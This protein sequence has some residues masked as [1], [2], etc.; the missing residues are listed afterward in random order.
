[1][2][3]SIR[4][5]QLGANDD[6][7]LLLCWNVKNNT[8]VKKGDIICELETTKALYDI[9]AETNGYVY[10]L[11]EEGKSFKVGEILAIISENQMTEEQIQKWIN[12]VDNIP[13]YDGKI[14][15]KQSKATEKA[16]LL[17]QLNGVD[18]GEIKKNS[19]RITESDVREYIV[20][21]IGFTKVIAD[22]VDDIYKDN[23]IERIAIIGGG[24]GAVQ[25]ID[26]LTKISS[27]KAVAIFD[28][29][30]QLVNK[31][32][33]GIPILG[34]VSVENIVSKNRNNIFDTVIISFGSNIKKKTYL[35]EEL[36]QQG[37]RFSNIIHPSV[38]IGMNV[39]IGS[40]NVIMALCHLGPCVTI[41]N[42]NFI[43][44]YCSI[45]HH[46]VLN[47]HCAFGP[48]VV[49]SGAV[50]IGSGVNFGTGIFIEPKI[51]I[52]DNSIISSGCIILKNI[53]DNTILKH[54]ENFSMRTLL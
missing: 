36:I 2:I 5:Q 17:A 49:T 14:K 3:T 1:M 9:E 11:C 21:S 41:G 4:V 13:V 52:G 6:S 25:I 12:E 37:I 24:N 45:E 53:P 46:S 39:K 15:S 19:G 33:A 54:H 8:L 44:A 51:R 26:A 10:L 7:A 47:N 28:D 23:R 32:I 31:Y 30:P 34:P 42:N 18:I 27:Q 43:S 22:K 50:T 38:C 48:N 35:F 16:I 40:G 20:N 29:D